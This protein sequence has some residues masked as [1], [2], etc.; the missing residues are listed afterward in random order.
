MRIERKNRNS[1]AGMDSEPCQ[2]FNMERF[3]ETRKLFS[4]NVLS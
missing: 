2:T 4:Q 3:A 1:Y